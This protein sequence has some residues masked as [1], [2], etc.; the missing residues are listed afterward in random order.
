M[1]TFRCEGCGREYSVSDE[2]QGQRGKCPCG[3]IIT[4]PPLA[5]SPVAKV[6][7]TGFKAIAAR[8]IEGPLYLVGKLVPEQFRTYCE[9]CKKPYE[10]DKC[11]RCF[12]REKSPGPFARCIYCGTQFR[13]TWRYCPACYVQSEIDKAHLAKTPEDA[14]AHWRT[15]YEEAI[16]HGYDF[17]FADHLAHTHYLAQA[18]FGAAAKKKLD[19]L[20]TH[21]A[22]EL[23]RSDGGPQHLAD[24]YAAMSKVGQGFVEYYV[25]EVKRFRQNH[26]QQND[27]SLSVSLTVETMLLILYASL[28]HYYTQKAAPS[29]SGKIVPE[30]N[31]KTNIDRMKRVLAEMRKGKTGRPEALCDLVDRHIAGLPKVDVEGLRKE[32]TEKLGQFD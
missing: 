24:Y 6:E 3:A 32:V 2:R 1:I 16:E 10:G 14:L 15:A 9:I 27:P 19:L 5:P 7:E 31:R 29:K 13:T 23:D 11:P 28:T 17:H 8:A 30:S 20:A 21:C 18:G 25:T 26:N 22:E 4:V 12:E